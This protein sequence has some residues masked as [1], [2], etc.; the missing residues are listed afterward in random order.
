MSHSQPLSVFDSCQYAEDVLEGLGVDR[1]TLVGSRAHWRF[2]RSHPFHVMWT[3]FDRHSVAEGR[4]LSA[5]WRPK[6]SSGRCPSDLFCSAV[7]L[8]VTLAS[9]HTIRRCEDMRSTTRPTARKARRHRRAPVLGKLGQPGDP[10][11]TAR[12]SSRASGNRSWQARHDRPSCHERQDT[13]RVPRR[14]LGPARWLRHEL[15]R[16]R[17][18]RLRRRT[19]AEPRVEGHRWQP[20]RSVEIVANRLQAPS[21]KSTSEAPAA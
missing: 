20:R 16:Q 15:A 12:C 19:A 4:C 1:S 5:A 14:P 6:A 9:I 13:R 3:V 10:H 11:R 7:S 18:P 17:P 2:L 8:L 21:S